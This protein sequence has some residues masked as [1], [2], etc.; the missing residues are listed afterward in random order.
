M[1]DA[2]KN[3][4]AIVR[5]SQPFAVR[6]KD[7]YLKN[8]L[9]WA[10]VNLIGVRATKDYYDNKF[11]DLLGV[12]TDDKAIIL[13]ATTVPGP[14][15]TPENC[16]KYGVIYAAIV[17]LGFHEKAFGLCKHRDHPDGF[18]LRARTK[19]KCFIDKNKDSQADETPYFEPPNAGMDIHAQS[20]GD[21]DEAVNFASAGCQVA[22]SREL[23]LNIFM[24]A[25]RSSAEGKK[26]EKGRFNYLLTAA[27]QFPLYDAMKKETL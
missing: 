27:D 4:F 5:D 2:I 17:C 14:F 11:N 16:K 9:D 12:V 8:G 21:T 15:W 6:L 20:I 23:F 24:P 7:Y 13:R 26:G 18:A 1:I 10:E 25:I 22:Q 3:A 19:L